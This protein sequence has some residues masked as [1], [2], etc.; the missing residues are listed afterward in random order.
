MGANLTTA[1][2][3]P[4]QGCECCHNHS[5]NKK[6]QRE[7]AFIPEISHFELAGDYAYDSNNC[8]LIDSEQFTLPNMV[9][10]DGNVTPMG[11]RSAYIDLDLL[12]T[13]E[14]RI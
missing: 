4:N 6:Y 8:D 9:T 11:I 13:I 7:Q 5:K 1:E 3:E 2:H 12:S 10:L 14:S